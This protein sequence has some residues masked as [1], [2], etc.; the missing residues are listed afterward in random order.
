MGV[1]NVTPDSFSDGGRWLD[2]E[3]AVAHARDLLVE[4]A[5]VIDVGGES[6]RPG[7]TP[8]GED[9]ELR[10][11]LPVLEALAGTCRLSI[12]TRHEVVARRAVAAGASIVN[13]VS[14][15]LAHVAADTGTA[16]IG[17][18]SRGV[19]ATPASAAGYGDVVAEVRDELVAKAEA[20][21]ALG[22][23][24]VWIDPGLGFAKDLH[25]NVALIARLDALVATGFP[26]VL[27]AS[28]KIFLGRL[29]AA[30]DAR[31]AVALDTPPVPAADRVEGSLAVAVWAM[32]VGVGMVRV[33]DVAPTVQART[34]V[35]APT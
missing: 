1:L 13:D 20:A 4:G 16:W 14:G 6:T 2:P 30:S 32:A 5:D 35:G 33:H 7:A 27:G 18:H 17:V 8:V 23:G 19:P 21:V 10:R 22:V 26:V 25:H 11:V 29:L 15:A 3:L 31:T 9:E 24:E 34:L 28:R 12:D